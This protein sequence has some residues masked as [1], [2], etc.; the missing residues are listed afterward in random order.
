[1]DQSNEATP[2]GRQALLCHANGK[3][4]YSHDNEPIQVAKNRDHQ[5]TGD[6]QTTQKLNKRNVTTQ[7][8]ASVDSVPP[9]II[10]PMPGSKRNVDI[11]P[12]NARRDNPLFLCIMQLLVSLAYTEPKVHAT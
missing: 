9:T 11:P 2:S 5:D 7:F 3:S 1:V 6:P 10:M 12:R 8:L 4:K